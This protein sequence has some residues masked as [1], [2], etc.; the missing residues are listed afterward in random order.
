MD[1]S[2]RDPILFDHIA[3]GVRDPARV[4][5]LLVGDL[6]GE[7]VSAGPGAGFLWYQWRFGG[8]GVLE[9]LEPDGPIDGFL[10][11][12]LD[13]RGP[14][15][16]HVTFKVP[17][18]AASVARATELGYDVVGLNLDDAGWKEAFL[19]PK[20]AQG[21]VVQLVESRPFEGEWSG[22]ESSDSGWRRPFPPEPEPAA[23]PVA[24]VGLRMV[25][26]DRERSLAQWQ[27]LLGADCDPSADRL[28][29]HWES[30][31][32]RIVVDI[33][34]DREQGPVGLEWSADRA[35]A[36]PQTADSLLGTAN[37]AMAA[38]SSG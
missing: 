28:V 15:I 3:V 34:P 20:Q 11:R 23:E 9:V 13:S 14:G 21:V 18:H 1:N 12:F 26:H 16:H 24:L 31:P 22:D 5:P 29:F 4:T 25:S 37:F 19:H 27:T 38:S 30:S 2:I 36:I 10:Y 33:V 17:D 35:F 32:M 7:Q 8:A 6:G